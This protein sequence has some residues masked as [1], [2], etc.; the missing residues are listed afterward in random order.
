MTLPEHAVT[1][2]ASKRRLLSTTCVVAC[3]CLALLCVLWEIRLAPLKPGGSWLA[4]KALPICLLLPGLIKR[5]LYSYQALSLLILLY[6]AEG[7]VRATSDRL[8]NSVL[9]AWGEVAL[10]L[11][12]FV[13]VLMYTH[14]FKNKKPAVTTA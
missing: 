11:I 12:I 6:L 3:I 9:L 5:R 1:V 7:L 10:S 14:T 13:S 2:T 4:L 8:A